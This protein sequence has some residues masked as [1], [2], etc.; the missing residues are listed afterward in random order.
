MVGQNQ[1]IKYIDELT[2]IR[3]LAAWWV[4]LYHFREFLAPHIPHWLTQ[5]ISH[6]YLAVDFFFILSGFVIFVS[7][8][9]AVSNF[10]IKSIRVFYLKRL[11]RI[12]PLH[13]ATLIAA[14]AYPLAVYF[15]KGD[16]DSS[17]RYDFGAFVANI[18]LVQ[19]WGFIKGLTWNVP[20]WSISAEF[21]SYLLFPA[22]VV[23]VIRIRQYP[24]VCVLFALLSMLLLVGVAKY[25]DLKNIG[26]NI[27]EFGVIRC[28][29]QFFVGCVLA[30]LFLNHNLFLAR[31]RLFVEGVAVLGLVAILASDLKDYW[32]MPVTFSAI[33]VTISV[34]RSIYSKLLSAKFIQI[35]G[36]IS[37]STY[38]LHFIFRDWYKAFFVKEGQEPNL[39]VLFG[40]FVLI[41]VASYASYQL[42]EV[43]LQL[44][45][46]KRLRL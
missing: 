28:F 14:L 44:A 12:Y 27:P 5:F 23:L 26:D 25:F 36:F 42:I 16:I 13:L 22:M 18:F 40:I 6:G 19:D 32:I 2:G 31:Y 39:Y 7:N 3:G 29:F 46:R 10:S 33:I 38:M 9:K 37:Y 8:G 20:S 45:V 4:V 15:Y 43:R 35:M 30:N 41:F 17:A 11:A 1:T 34:G 21:F 24:K